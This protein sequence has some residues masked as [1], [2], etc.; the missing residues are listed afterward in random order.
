M[1][2]IGIHSKQPKRKASYF[3]FMAMESILNAMLTLPKASQI[4][5]T[6]FLELIREIMDIVLLKVT[7]GTVLL[8]PGMQL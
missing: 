6:T 5:A 7:P 1:L 4:K 3:L 2:T 8:N